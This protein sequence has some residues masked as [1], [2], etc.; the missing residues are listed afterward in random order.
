MS[1]GAEPLVQSYDNQH[2]D[3]PIRGIIVEELQ[4]VEVEELKFNGGRESTGATP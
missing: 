3:Q 1:S 4:R 2:T